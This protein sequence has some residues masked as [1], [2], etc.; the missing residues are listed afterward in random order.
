MD[1]TF[2]TAWKHVREEGEH[3]APHI[4]DYHELVYYPTNRGITSINS[5][6]HSFH[7]Q[8][9]AIMPAEISHEETHHVT[10]LLFCIGFRTDMPL[11][12]GV[13]EDG[14]G[15]IFQLVREII[16]ESYEQKHA[17]KEMLI[18]KIAELS[19]QLIRKQI[20]FSGRTEPLN[21]EYVLNFLSNNYAEKITFSD[22]AEQLNLSYD[23]FQ[24]RFR[25]LY[26]VS[27]QQ[28]LLQKRLSVAQ[29]LLLDSKSSCTDI[30][31]RC[32]FSNSSQF[33]MIFRRELG[34]TPSQFRKSKDVHL[35]NG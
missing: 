7:P 29:D 30:A 26:G 4:H 23:Y 32:G 11:P 6:C 24:H 31:Y 3:V 21:F 17:Y 22:L 20:K 19:I 15:E 5:N 8:S 33:S 13:F 34:V 16:S 35:A 25:E 18:A 2:V 14:S 28:Y 10:G 9:Y 1:V 12:A 27:P